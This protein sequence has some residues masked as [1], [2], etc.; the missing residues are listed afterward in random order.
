MWAMNTKRRVTL[1]VG[2]LILGA[3]LLMPPW[4]NKGY[5]PRSGHYSVPLGYRFIFDAPSGGG[6]DVSRLFVQFAATALVFG[7]LFAFFQDR[8]PKPPEP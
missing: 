7:G 4:I 8:P 6:I 5:S 1:L 3:M 2:G